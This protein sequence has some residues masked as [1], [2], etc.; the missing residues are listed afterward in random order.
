MENAEACAFPL[1][2]AR[3]SLPATSGKKARPNSPAAIRFAATTTHAIA[4][5]RDFMCGIKHNKTI[6]IKTLSRCLKSCAH[7]VLIY[8]AG[9][10][11][12]N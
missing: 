7:L 4:D 11:K 2:T 12:L 10:L 3:K 9:G 5:L 6:A 8:L 1:S